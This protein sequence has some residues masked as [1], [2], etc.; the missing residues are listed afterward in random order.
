[1]IAAG[2]RDL[3]FDV[4]LQLRVGNRILRLGQVTDRVLYLREIEAV[5]PTDADLL[6]TIDG[7]LTAHPIHLT[8]GIVA[9]SE[10]VE[11]QL[12]T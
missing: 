12:R 9:G 5:G 4:L 3:S 10:T 7:E 8:R 6:I 2:P 1:M 11:Y